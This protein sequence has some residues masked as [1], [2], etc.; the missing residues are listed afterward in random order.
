[1]ER[2]LEFSVN[3]PILMLAAAFMTLLVVFHE[4]RNRGRGRVEVSPADAVRLINV[5][6]L[7]LD[8]RSAD[9]FATGHISGARNVAPADMAERAGDLE[10]YKSKPVLTCC[11]NGTTGTRMVATLR[12]QGFEQVFNLQGG[13]TAWQREHLPLE[14][15]GAKKG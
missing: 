3:H 1:M 5:G 8:V 15:S 13:L 12:K 14:K 9:E 4:T 10:K 7:V 2:F 11:M 6:A